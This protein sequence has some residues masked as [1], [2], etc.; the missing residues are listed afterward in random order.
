MTNYKNIKTTHTKSIYRIVFYNNNE[1]FAT[2]SDDSKIQIWKN[3]PTSGKF[4][5][6]L[7]GHKDRIWDMIMLTNGK[8]ATCSSDKTIRIWDIHNYTCDQVLTSHT[9]YVCALVEL[10]NH[11][12]SSGSHDRSIKF[13]DLTSFTL[14]KTIKDS[15]QGRIMIMIVVSEEELAVG[16]ESSIKLYNRNTE[17]CAKTI[18]G[19]TGLIRDLYLGDNNNHLFSGSDDKT[20]KIWDIEKGVCIKTFTGHNHSANK[21]IMF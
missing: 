11:I 17:K 2:A 18:S 14:K 8:I 9:G 20:I 4:I 1:N 5:K 10:P 6:M 16:S 19:H 15:S 13:W 21:I 12:L 7:S 3:E